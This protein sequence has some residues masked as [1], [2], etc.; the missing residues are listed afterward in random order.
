MHSVRAAVCQNRPAYDKEVNVRHAIEMIGRAAGEGAAL[1]SLSEIFYWP[2]ERKGIQR[3]ADTDTRVLDQLRNTAARYGIHLCT[4]SM[5][6]KGENGFRNTAFLVGP[7]GETLLEYSKT[8]LFDVEFEGLSFRESAFI[9]PGD[10][11]GVAHTGIGAIGMLVCYDI[12][13]PEMARKLALDGAEILVVPAA[14]NTISGPAH[15]HVMFRARAIENQVFVVAASQ[16][17]VPGAP[18]EAYG[19]SM[20]VDPWGRVIAEAGEDEG[21]VSAD[22]RADV[23]VD[24]RARLPLLSQRRP[25]LY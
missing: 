6:I 5:A 17:R 15:W 22:L 10:T 25:E 1:V 8:H 18:Y 24:T 7:S 3:A 14:F 21:V 23:L 12:R 11:A 20:V 13:F 19:H 2:Y 4:G 9:E 16:A